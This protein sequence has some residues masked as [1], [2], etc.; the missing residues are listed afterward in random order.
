MVKNIIQD[1]NHNM[2]LQLQPDLHQQ[3]MPQEKRVSMNSMSKHREK[4]RKLE[5]HLDMLNQQLQLHQLMINQSPDVQLQHIQL[6]LIQIIHH[7]I[8][9]EDQLIHNTLDLLLVS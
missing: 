7:L 9:I 4:Q 6:L 3:L 2:K 5:L 1:L 8:I